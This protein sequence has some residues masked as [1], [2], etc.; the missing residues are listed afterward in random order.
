MKDK[1]KFWDRIAKK[2]ARKPVPSQ[3]KYEEKLKKTQELFTS[4][5]QVLEVG[6]GTGT[7]SL[8]HA[9]HV[10]HI[11]ATDFSPNM[12][13]IA[14]DKA[15]AK[16]I[17]NVTFKTESIEAMAY[18]ENHFDVV[19]AHSILHL[20]ED[21]EHA[22]KDLLRITKPGGYFVSSTACI[23]DH[24]K[25]FKYLWPIVYKTGFFPNVKAFTSEHLRNEVSNSG[26]EIIYQWNP[27]GKTL[28]M[29]A[30]KPA[31]PMLEK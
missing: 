25:M 11:T 1:T 12:I 18:A 10:K 7:T 23:D 4:Q 28:F 3:E 27:D 13:Q 17:K 19:M 6:C 15:Q 30:R 26:F 24:L 8:I 2:Y 16:N 20:L 22:I 31:E 21:K 5:M 29:I 14:Q 9:P